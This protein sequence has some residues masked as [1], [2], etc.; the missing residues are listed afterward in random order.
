MFAN[1]LSRF[2][3]L[4]L[5]RGVV[6][7]LFGLTLFV[8]P[9]LSLASLVL[10]FAAFMLVDGFSNVV[11]AVRGRH[12]YENWWVL[13]LG[14]I[15]GAGL[16]ILTFW[17]PQIT[18]LALLFYI[19]VWAIA[20][21][22]LEIVAA[23]QLRKEIAGEGWLLLGGLASIAFGMLLMARPDAGALAVL[24]LIASYAVVFGVTLMVL[25]FK[26]RRF[27][28]RVQAAVTA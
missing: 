17:K 11:T 19:A 22:L 13:L 9:N 4:L 3:H 25:A 18:A 28:K 15:T 12:E 21:G 2:W 7:V 14:G 27:V 1:V 8:W 6:A 5:L 10:L 20:T 24:W 23:I 16:G 26:A